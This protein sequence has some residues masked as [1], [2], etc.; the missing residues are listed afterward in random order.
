MWDTDIQIAFVGSFLT[1][2]TLT[3]KEQAAGKFLFSIK[4][5]KVTIVSYGAYAPS[6][7]E[8]HK[9]YLIAKYS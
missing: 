4:Y 5:S 2:I 9:F 8:V 3:G 6:K 1:K 7:H